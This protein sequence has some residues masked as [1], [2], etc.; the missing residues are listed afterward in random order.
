M[1]NSHRFLLSMNNYLGLLDQWLIEGKFTENE[2]LSLSY[3]MLSAGI[4]T[5]RKTHAESTVGSRNC[6]LSFS[7][8]P[9]IL[10]P[11]CCTN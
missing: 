5:V 10:Q 3:D 6:W 8:R 11:S 7:C 2:T 1:Y 9:P 4:D